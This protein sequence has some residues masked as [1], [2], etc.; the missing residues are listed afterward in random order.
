MEPQSR[1]LREPEEKP[2]EFPRF[3]YSALDTYNRCP[4]AWLLKYQ[5]RKERL[6]NKWMTMGSAAHEL[7]ALYANECILLG[8]PTDID[9]ARTMRERI[10]SLDEDIRS[11]VSM[12]FDQ[13]LKQRSFDNL[14]NLVVEK[15]LGAR[16][17]DG[18][19]KPCDWR[20]ADLVGILDLGEDRRE[21]EG[22]F[23]ITD[24]KTGYVVNSNEL[25]GD[26][27]FN[28]YAL[29]VS[30]HFP[31]ERYILVKDFVRWNI[32][33][34]G[35]LYPDQLEIFG[36]DL[37]RQIRAVI[38][39]SEF[40]KRREACRTCDVVHHCISKEFEPRQDISITQMAEEFRRAKNLIRIYEP[41]M[42]DYVNQVGPIVLDGG[43]TYTA[44]GPTTRTEYDVR[45]VVQFLIQRGVE[46]EAVW[47]TVK[48]SNQELKRL[49]KKQKLTDQALAS[50]IKTQG[51]STRFGF[52]SDGG[53]EED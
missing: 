38:E 31:A 20:D 30:L 49:L 50:M 36:K 43:E 13:F 16:M 29:L 34:A 4:F 37:H 47:K 53:G 25:E 35:E 5:E 44:K 12:L 24:Y 39:A 3:S 9:T 41:A 28:I 19:W 7:F 6:A 27:Q 21:Y 17:V 32:Q 1:K 2:R 23:K 10:K 22:V 26:L 14:E 46:L 52:V 45:P 48:L 42:K 18:E 33:I 40:N 51:V 11:E 15:R 8:T